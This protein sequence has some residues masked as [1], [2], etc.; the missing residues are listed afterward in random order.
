MRI[1]QQSYPVNM[2]SRSHRDLDERARRPKRGDAIIGLR[3]QTIGREKVIVV[4]RKDGQS[5]VL[6]SGRIIR[7]SLQ[8]E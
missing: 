2:P 5:S 7:R 6:A 8:D 4:S 1:A 3:D